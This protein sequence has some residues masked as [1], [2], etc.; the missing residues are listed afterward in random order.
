MKKL[1][2]EQLEA[3]KEKQK[4]KYLHG[5]VPRLL[6]FDACA[7]LAATASGTLQHML[8]T[9]FVGKLGTS[10][11]AA[12]GL[13]APVIMVFSFV[14]VG[15]TSGISALSAQ[16][17]GRKDRDTALNLT[18]LG[19]KLG[20]ALAAV[21]GL[22]GWF[23]S[24]AVLRAMRVSAEASPQILGYLHI[25]FAGCVLVVLT[26]V[27]NG[28]LI[29]TGDAMACSLFTVLGLLLGM[30]LD[31]LFIFGLGPLPSL[32]VPGS[33]VATIFA[34]GLVCA[35]T[36]YRLAARHHLL[37]IRPVGFAVAKELMVKIAG[38]ATP[39]TLGKIVYPIGGVVGASCANLFGD[40]AIAG[41]SV[42]GRV[43]ELPLMF[44]AAL[45]MPLMPFF[46]QN[47]GAG[48]YSRVRAGDRFATNFAVFYCV[49]A[50]VV[51]GL[52]APC[53]VPF[54]TKDANV[55][56]MAVTALRFGLWS[57]AG[58]AVFM[59]TS[60]FFTACGKPSMTLKLEF[61]WCFGLRIPLM[62]VGARVV[63][64]VSAFFLSMVVADTL[65]GVVSVL[66]ARRMAKRFPADGVLPETTSV[67]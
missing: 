64:T 11:L 31:P 27:A 12:M 46:A 32:G 57:L 56:D 59:Y 61:L 10:S 13:V 40:V 47:Y 65:G 49:A 24:P 34:Q 66:S 50:A 60:A 37:T 45:S 21:I 67:R 29:A 36:C 23:G 43:V 63:G 44:I 28:V 7:M 55:I 20:V 58:M 16:A 5:S 39:A 19:L 53:I 8:N 2:S 41:F 22:S 14:L 9:F 38:Y 3:I 62:L 1:T 52:L 17:I 54:F 25:W 18:S 51:F 33:A 4:V 15:L 42:A 6:L 30:A 35:A 48:Q 26:S